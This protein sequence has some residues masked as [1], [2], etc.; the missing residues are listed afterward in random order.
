MPVARITG[1]SERPGDVCGQHPPEDRYHAS[2]THVMDVLVGAYALVEA[3]APHVFPA[4]AG[5]YP[6]VCRHV[7]P[8]IECEPRVHGFVGPGEKPVL[9]ESQ[10][11]EC[12]GVSYTENSAVTA[13]PVEGEERIEPAAE[14]VAPAGVIGE[15]VCRVV[16]AELHGMVDPPAASHVALVSGAN[17]VC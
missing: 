4:V 12:K 6:H 10:I 5:G 8:Q 2:Y 17:A 11:L 16:R 1:H 9:V 3:V 14:T 13:H 7:E 15:E